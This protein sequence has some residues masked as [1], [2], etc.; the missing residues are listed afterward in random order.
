MGAAITTAIFSPAGAGYESREMC[1]N[2]RHNTANSFPSKFLFPVP[3]KTFPSLIISALFLLHPGTA[4]FFFAICWN[5]T[6]FAHSIAEFKDRIGSIVPPDD[7]R[8]R[9]KKKSIACI[10]YTTIT[11]GGGRF[12][13]FI[14][15]ELL[16]PTIPLSS[17][18]L[19]KSIGENTHTYIHH[20]R[21]GRSWVKSSQILAIVGMIHPLHSPD[22]CTGWGA[23]ICCRRPRKEGLA[24]WA[25]LI[26]ESGMLHARDVFV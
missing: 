6:F 23:H 5:C 22:R 1:S 3:C 13:F 8:I 15:F 17:A 2:T 12:M 4:Q 14:T 10:I 21:S 20:L 26:A 16:F 18:A 7:A 11:C 19:T 25:Y 9:N 24:R